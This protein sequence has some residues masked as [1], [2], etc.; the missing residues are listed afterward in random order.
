VDEKENSL[1]KNFRPQPTT[2]AGVGREKAALRPALRTLA[3]QKQAQQ[4]LLQQ[5]TLVSND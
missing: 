4:Q 3:I 5:Q 2:M 1:E